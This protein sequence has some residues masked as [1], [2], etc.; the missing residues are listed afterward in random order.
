MIASYERVMHQH[1]IDVASFEFITDA[2]GKA[3]TYDINTNTNYN[4]R[5]EQRAGV[6]GMDTLIDYLC[7]GL[8]GAQ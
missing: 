6:S 7:A 3:Y 4:T 8:E 2:S 1:A 5:A